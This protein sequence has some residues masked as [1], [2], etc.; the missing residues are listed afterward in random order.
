MAKSPKT[1]AQSSAKSTAK[2]AADTATSTASEAA[3][4]TTTASTKAK[5][6]DKSSDDDHRNPV[7][8]FIYDHPWITMFIFYL[9]LG[10]LVKIWGWATIIFL[11]IPVF[12]FARL[13]FLTR[14]PS[15]PME[16]DMREKVAWW[17]KV[18][19]Y[20]SAFG[21]ASIVILDTL[22][23]LHVFGE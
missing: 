8:V 10:A 11:A 14:N 21:L 20:S 19:L 13:W 4:S 23:I 15:Q 3:A 7:M 5:S 9:L 16:Q 18:G 22:G 6:V 12:C 2:S 1:D 17:S